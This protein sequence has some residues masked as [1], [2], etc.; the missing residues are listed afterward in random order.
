MRWASFSGFLEA[1]T[2]AIVF[3]SVRILNR[4][5]SSAMA[6]PTDSTR[7]TPLNVPRDVHRNR[8][9]E[10]RHEVQLGHLLRSVPADL[11]VLLV[12]D[13]RFPVPP[14]DEEQVVA[15]EISLGRVRVLVYTE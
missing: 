9:F 6:S 8:L 10:G 14:G 13:P 5:A 15:G 3:A 12:R 7:A 2:T 1:P 11:R 4:V